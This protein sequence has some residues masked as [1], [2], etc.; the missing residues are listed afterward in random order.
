[1]EP[2]RTT[3]IANLANRVSEHRKAK[4]AVL[5][6]LNEF[7]DLLFA[8]LGDIVDQLASSTEGVGNADFKTL[9]DGTQQLKFMFNDHE[10]A[11][12]TSERTAFPDNTDETIWIGSRLQEECGLICMFVD[13]EKAVSQPFYQIYVFGDGSWFGTGP[14]GPTYHEICEPLD[15]NSAATVA[16]SILEHY[17]SSLSSTWRPRSEITSDKFNSART[18]IGIGFATK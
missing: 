18:P 5:N 3:R 4:K 7:A 15:S 14:A 9:P 16:M 13:M 1:M 6:Q 8:Q 17:H 11:F 10:L 2:D 12:R